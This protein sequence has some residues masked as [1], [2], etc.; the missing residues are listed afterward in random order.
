MSFDAWIVAFGLT[1]LLRLMRVASDGAALTVFVLVAAID[2]WLLFRFFRGGHPGRAPQ[3]A[4]PLQAHDQ[5]SAVRESL[6][7]F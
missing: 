4:E 7:R 2:S 1:S 6:E 5:P 3:P